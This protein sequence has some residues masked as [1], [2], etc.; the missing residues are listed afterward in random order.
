MHVAYFR[1]QNNPS[2]L[3]IA[4][5][6]T[7]LLKDYVGSSS[8]SFL[9]TGYTSL[10]NPNFISLH[11]D[12]QERIDQLSK[13]LQAQLSQPSLSTTID[14]LPAFQ[15]H[16]HIDN[17]HS[18]Q[19]K[20]HRHLKE[21]DHSNGDNI[22]RLS[23]SK[24]D[25]TV[26]C[27]ILDHEQEVKVVAIPHTTL[28]SSA[29]ALRILH[30]FEHVLR[31]VNNLTEQSGHL[32][33]K[34]DTASE[35]DINS[36]WKWNST[37]PTPESRTAL[38]VFAEHV[39]HRP[40]SLAV[41]AWDGDFT[42]AELDS[43]STEFSLRL[44]NEVSLGPGNIVPLC[45]EK[46]KWTPVA[47]LSVIKT[48]AAFTLIDENL[49]N[50]RLR[51]IAKLVKQ[52]TILALSSGSQKHRAQ[53]MASRVIIVDSNFLETTYPPSTKTRAQIHVTPDSLLYIVF[54]SGSTG[55]PKA[56]MLSHNNMC[57]FVTLSGALSDLTPRSRILALSSYAYDVSL[58]DAFISLLTGACLCI[59]SSWECKNNVDQ[60]VENYKVTRLMTTPSISKT[61]RPSDSPSLEVLVLCGEPCSED[62]LAR[63]RGSHT[64]I[65]NSY[66]PAE[67]TVET[68][69][70]YNV[71][72]SKKP[73]VIGKGLGACWIVDPVDHGR[74]AP[75]GGVGELVLEGPLV[76]LGYLHDGETTRKKFLDHA[77][78][79]ENG[80]PGL[81]NERKARLYRSGDLVRYT[82]DGDIEY[83][84]RGD[85]QVKIRGQ[86]VEL[87][88]VSAH[89]QEF[90]PP[91]IQWCPEV[92]KLESGAELLVVFLVVNTTDEPKDQ[93]S[94]RL[95]TLVDRVNTELQTRLP[96]S[97]VPSAYAEI[98]SV[99]LS[100]SGKVDHRRLK[101][102]G[103][104]LPTS[105]WIV[106][107]NKPVAEPSTN[108]SSYSPINDKK[109]S[110]ENGPV[111]GSTRGSREITIPQNG[112]G[113]NSQEQHNKLETL[114]RVWS[115][116]LHV[117]IKS[118]HDSDTFFSHGGESLTAIKFVSAASK[119][120]IQLDVATIF[121]YPQ[122]SALS[123]KAKWSYVSFLEPLVRFSLLNSKD[124][125]TEISSLYGI[126]IDDIEDA[127]PCT[128]LQE[129]LISA[130]SLNSTNYVGRGTFALPKDIDIE[131]FAQAWQRV[132]AVHSILRTRIVDTESNGL[133]QVV[134]RDG[135]VFGGIQTQPLASY[136]KEDSQNKL[137]LGT[138]L[139]RWG[140]VRH[141]GLSY[142]V[143]TM[144]HAIYDG[145]TLPR[146]GQE[147]FRA[148]NGVRIQPSVGFNIFV[149]HVMSISYK[150]AEEFWTRQL[151][152]PER[153]AAFP[154]LR[155][156][157]REPRADSVVS[158]S[159]HVPSNANQDTSI[160]SLLRAAWALLVSKL[161]GNDDVIFGATVS[162][163][164]VAIHGIEDL[165][166]P[167]ISTIPVRVRI[168]S[169]DSVSTF[170]RAVQNQA[171]EAMPFENLGLHNIRRFNAT[172]RD[173][174]KFQTLFIVDPPGE[175]SIDI[176]KSLSPSDQELKE[177]LEQLDDTLSA[178]LSNFNEYSLM[179]I[180]MQKNEQ[181]QIK[182]SYDSRILNHAD[183]NL[184]LDQFV[185]V[186]EQLG[187]SNNV[188]RSLRDLKLAGISDI[189]KIWQWNEYISPGVKESV[190]HIIGQTIS[191]HPEA[192]AIAA[193]DGSAS[194][195][196]LDK[197]SSNLCYSLQSKG[198]GR[199]SLVPICMEK[200]MWATVA[201]LAILKTG[202][203]F[204]AMDIISQPKKRL[205]IIVDQINATC[206]V[207]TSQTTDLARQLCEE[208][209]VCDHKSQYLTI[210]TNDTFK[211]D[212]QSQPSD[213]AFVVFTSGSTG[214]PKGIIITHENFST[215]IAHHAR[216]LKLTKDSRIFDFASYSFDI[217]VHNAL[218]ALSVGG[219]LCIPSE[220]DRK[221]DIEG[222]FK[223]LK[224]NWA[225]ITPSVARLIDPSAIPGLETLVLSGEAVSKDIVQTWGK[226]V[227][228][229][230]AYGPAECQICTVNGTIAG[231]DNAA[232]IGLGVACATWIV[233]LGTDNLTPIGAIGELVI[234][235][236]IVS[237][238]YLNDSNHSFI[239][240]PSWLTEGST[241]VPGRKGHLYRTG[242]LARYRPNGTIVYMGRASTQAKL[243]GQR[244]ELSEVEFYVKKADTSLK[245]VIADVVDVGGTNILTAFVVASNDG[246]VMSLEKD[247][248]LTVGP[249]PPPLGLNRAL[250]SDLPSYMI[251]G[252]FLQISH[253]PLSTTRKVDRNLLK[254]RASSISWEQIRELTRHEADAGET[255]LTPRQLDLA[256]IWSSVLKT[257]IAKITAHSDFFQLGGDS[258]S[259]MRLVKYSQ[260]MGLSFTVADVFRHSQLQELTSLVTE[261]VEKESIANI[262]QPFSLVSGK[263]VDSLVST[264]ATVCNV[265][266]DAIMD[267]YPCT[268]FQE[269][270]F[271]L[272]A[273]NSSAY[274]QHTLL[275]FGND[276]N[277]E[278][279]LGAWYAVIGATSILRTRLVQSEDAQL[280][281]VVVRQKDQLWNWYSSTEEYI[282]ETAKV[283][284]EL[285]NEL[286]R[287][288]VVRDNSTTP[289]SYI[290]IWTMHHAVYDAWTMDIILRQVSEYYQSQSLYTITPSY[291][292]FVDF[293]QRQEG[294]SAKWWRNYLSG[295]SN[296]SF[297]PKTPMSLVGNSV[298]SLTRKEFDLPRIIP[299][300]Y[301]PAVLLRAAWAIVMA[302]H[303]SSEAV[304]FG[305]TRLGRN[306]P[307]KDMEK[308]PGP[309]IASAPILLNVD[310]E[311]AI[312]SLLDTVRE[313]GIQM[314]EFEHLGLQNISRVSDD[315][316][317]ACNFQTLLVF[318]EAEDRVDGDSIFRVDDTI[319]DIRNFNNNHLLIY[320]SLTRTSLVTQAVF[321]EHAVSRGYVDLVL[322]QLHSTF[323]A[324]CDL[325]LHTLV[326]ELDVASEQDLTQIWEW[327]ATPAQTV[328]AFIHELIAQNA[329]KHP[330]KL[331]V[332]GHDGQMTYKELDQYSNNLAAQ[333]IARG[334][335]INTFVPLC[336]EKSF[337]VPAAI[338]KLIT[339]ALGAHLL[340]SSPSQV[341]LAQ[342]LG[343]NVLV[344]NENTYQ[345]DGALETHPIIEASPRDTDRLMYVCFTSGSTG[346]PKGVKVTHKNLA[347][348]AVAQTRELDFVCED[349]VYD[350]SS[351]AFDANIWHF[352]LGLV[353]GACVCIPSLEERT[354]NLAGSITA[355]KSTALFLTPSVARTI[356]PKD[357]PTVKRLYLGGEAVTPLDVSMWKDSL[358]L[359]GAYGPTETTPLCIFTR[360]FAPESA[361]N[362]GRGIGV[363]SWVV[364]PSNHDELVAIGAVGEMVNEGPLV[365]SGYH[366]LPKKTAQVFIE[367]PEFLQ[368]GFKRSRGR[369]GR[370]YKTGDL[371]RYCYDGTIQY[372]G[373]ADTQV[374]LR[375]QRV[376]FG[377]IEYHLKRA[378]P[379]VSTICD[380]VVHP[381]SG[382]P[383]LVA[384]CALSAADSLDK[385]S[386]RVYLSKRLPPYMVPEFFFRIE[387]IPRNKSGKVDRLNLREL[388][389][390]LLLAS[391]EQDNEG[392]VEYLHGP[393]T[394]NETILGALWATSLGQKDILLSPDTDFVDV[395]GDSIAA[396]KLS[397]L[398]R[399]QDI[400]LT[401]ADIIK[402]SKLSAMALSISSLQT[403]S[404]SPAPFSMINS[405]NREKI[406]AN[407]A[408]TCGVSVEDI[409]D[410]YPST[411]LQIELVAL[412]LKQ[413]QAYMKR[414]V[415]EVP[416]KVDVEKLV[417]AWEVVIKINA[418]LRTR[419]VE[420]ENIGLVQV[421]VKG[422]TWN[423][424]DSL[425]SYIDSSIASNRDLGSPLCQL[426]I[427]RDTDSSKIAWTIHHALYDEWSTLIID[428][429]LRRAY[430][431][432]T[433]QRPPSFNAVVAYIT[434]Q[435]RGKGQEFW[436]TRLSGCSSVN[437]YPQLPSAHYQV[438]PSQV[439]NCTIRPDSGSVRNLQA[440]VHAAW[441]LVVSK[442][443]GSNDVVFAATLAGR[444]IPVEG[445]EQV[446]GPTIT[447]VPIRIQLQNE[448]Q[449][450][451]ELLD[452]VEKD[453]ADMSPYQHMGIKNIEQ[454]NE[455]TRA[456]CKVQT[457]IV[458]TPS[459][460]SS[461][462]DANAI[463]TSTYDVESKEGGA[464][465]TFA[466]V[467]FVYPSKTHLDLQVVYDPAIFN[468][469]EIE[470]LTGRLESVI[471]SFNKNVL[472]SEID[473]LG[474]EDL[475]D[476]L[477]WNSNV[478]PSSSRLLHEVIL[479]SA[480]DNAKKL[481]IDAWDSK[482]SYSQLGKM[483]GALSM[484]LHNHGVG[485]GS[486][487]PILS[488]KSGY[489][490]VAALA[491]LKTGA[492]FL[493]LD[494]KQPL[495]RLV[496][497]IDQVKPKVILAA[498]SVR[499]LAT[500]L[501]GDIVLIE[502]CLEPISGKAEQFRHSD[503]ANIDDNACILFTSGT[504]GTPK[505]VMQTHRALSSAVQYQTAESGFTEKTR[506][507]EFA[508][509]SFDVSWNMIFKVLTVGGTLV[510][511]SE[512][513][514]HND[515]SGA[516]IRSAATLTELTASVARLLDPGQLPDLETLI[517]SGEP[518]DLREFEEW[519]P[520]A[521]VVVCY[522]PSECTSVATMN[523]GIGASSADAGIG[524]GAACVVWIVDPQNYRRLMPVGA[525]GEILIEGP[526]VGKG[527][528][529]NETL[530]SRSYLSLE[531]PKLQPASEKIQVI[532]PRKGFLS[533]DLARYDEDGNI[534][535][536]SRKDLQ[537]KLHGQRIELEEVQYHVS[538]LL[539][540]HVGPVVCCILGQSGSG[541]DQRL[542][543]FLV[544]D[545][546]DTKGIC[547]FLSP[548]QTTVNALEGLD[549]RIGAV[550]PKYMVPSVYYFITTLPR[551]HNGKI[552][553][554]RLMELADTAE[555]EHVYRGRTTRKTIR[556]NPS[557]PNEKA[558]Q[559]LWA[560]V[561]GTSAEHIGADDSF[562]DLNGDSISAM[563][564]VASARKLGFDLR[565]ADI[566]ATPKLSDLAVNFEKRDKK[567]TSGSFSMQPF[568]LLGGSPDIESI[569]SE[570]AVK[571]GI[572]AHE[573]IE[574][575][576]PCT[577]LQESMLAATIRY[578]GSFTSMR[579]YRV[580]NNVDESRLRAAWTRV[581]HVHRI[582]RT[583]LV[584]L[585]NYGVSQVIINEDSIAW[586]SYDSMHAF[587]QQADKIHMGPAT[588]LTRWAFIY[589][590]DKERYLV[591][592]IHHATYDGWTLQLIEDDVR[593]AYS[594]QRLDIDPVDIRPLVNYILTQRKEDS[595]AFWARQLAG[596]EDSVVFP[597]LPSHNYDPKPATYLEKTI[598][599]DVSATSG[600]TGL[601]GLLYGSWA[602]IVSHITGNQT[603]SL[604]TILTGRNAPIDGIDKVIGPAV[605]TVP[606]L[607]D[608]NMKLKVREFVAR[609]Q[610]MTACWI[611]HE[612]L[613]IQAIR[614]IDETCRAAC[615]FQ[616]V[617]VIQPP[618]RSQNVENGG[619]RDH[620]MEDVDETEV[621]GF[622]NQHS[623]LNQ[624]GLM[625]EVV[626]IDNTITVRA[627]FDSTL[628]SS[629]QVDRL[630]NLWEYMIQQISS[631]LQT[632]LLDTV[633]SLNYT[634]AQDLSDIWA[635][636]KNAPQ[637]IGP[638]R[639]VCQAIQS[640][641]HQQPDA[642][643]LDAWDGSMTYKRLDVLSSR[644]AHRLISSGVSRGH[645]VPLLFRKSLW[646]NV[647]M[648]AVLKAGGAFVPLDADHPEGHLRAIMQP[649]S[650]NIILCAAKTR[651]RAARLARNAIIVDTALDGSQDASKNI[652]QAPDIAP[653]TAHD[654]AY[655]VF[656]S[657]STGA[658][659]GVRISHENLAT[660]IH[661][662]AGAE[663]YQLNRHTRSLD[664]SSYSFDA[665]VCNFF[666]TVTQGGCL[667]VPSDETLK[668][669]IG[670]FINTSHV[671][672]AQLVPSVARTLDPEH[673]PNLKALVLTGE[674]LGKSDIEMW[675]HRVR[676]V[677]A[678]G[679]TE[680]TILCAIS[681]QISDHSQ[682]GS[683]GGGRGAN[684]W[685]TEIGNP[686][687]LATVGAVGEIL[688]EGP[689]VGAG[690]LGPY[691]YPLVENPS[692]LVSGRGNIP[693]RL[694]TLFR[695]G[696]Q[697]R[698]AEDGSIVFIGRI[699]SEIKLRGQRVDLAAIE[700]VVSS[701]IPRGLEFAAEIVQV[702][703]GATKGHERQM[704][705]VFVG[706]SVPLEGQEKTLDK[707]LQRLVPEL[708]SRLDA[709]LP[710]YL[711]P[712]AFVAFPEIPKTSSGK[713]DRRRLKELGTQIR[714]SQLTWIRGDIEKPIH[715]PPSSTI[716]SLL[717]TLWGE[718]LGIDSTT[719]SREDD[720]FQLGGDSLGVMRLTTKA[721]ERGLGLKTSDV[722]TSSKLALLA[723]RINQLDGTNVAYKPYSLARDIQD[724]RS[725]IQKHIAPVLK[726][727][728]SEVEDILPANGFQVDYMHSQEEPLGLQ[729]AYIDIG[730][731]T[732]WTKLIAACRTVVQTF[733]SLRARFV[734]HQGKYYQI[735]LR[736]APLA[737]E[738]VSTTEQI[739]TF[740]NRFCPADGHLAHVSDI[741]TKITLVHTGSDRR[742]V[743]LRLSHMQNDGWCT[744]RILQSLAAAFNDG[745]VDETP[746]WTSL[747]HYRD[748][749]AQ[750]SHL[751]WQRIL[752]KSSNLT[753]PLVY[754]P[755]GDQ[756][757][758]LRSYALPY[759][760]DAEDNRR[761]RPTVVVNVAWALVLQK[762]A[763]VQDAVFGN[764]TTGRNGSMPGLDSVVGPCVNML[765]FRLQLN[766][767]SPT[768]TRRQQILDL[769]EASAQQVDE[770][771][772]HEGLD[773]TDLVDKST[774]WSSGT[775]YTSAV[776]FRN[777][778]FEPELLL[779]NEKVVVT[780]Y[781]L[782]ARPHWTTV[783]VY[784][785]DSVLRLWLLA[786]PSEIGEDGADEILQMLSTYCEEIVKEL[787]S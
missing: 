618:R 39:A 152:D 679:P 427:I 238:G 348:A 520:R 544:N 195:S 167:T 16:L 712:E 28:S 785:E 758:T 241:S 710:V 655:A 625:M 678:Y 165:L 515:L 187:C 438:Q 629:T 253:I 261:V 488:P 602:A 383:M 371:V 374:K 494:S 144:H 96:P 571:C 527:Y 184:L 200:S 278:R 723:K 699:G 249:I 311:Q 146:L 284:M 693:G 708:K 9:A 408:A 757:R 670:S 266:R 439:F 271:A 749:S 489:V 396:M 573:K 716:E 650:A 440:K 14:E 475:E 285:G 412:T 298:N 669:D 270:V 295:A 49:P 702:N 314:Q 576:Y 472:V 658:A 273:S 350:F 675:A 725:F 773:W 10:D 8:V 114:K 234:E 603:V 245:E 437:V 93:I 212:A 428:E 315:A 142:L 556:R 397:N 107:Q 381:F 367:D 71:L 580:P 487:I 682:L 727:D 743:I 247:V 176:S 626:P 23:N 735:I 321:R 724:V 458:I 612:H 631:I 357:V 101:Q 19:T 399:K 434:S 360:L 180:I 210:G 673:L 540:G 132:T 88:E 566:F 737:V 56:I 20:S 526:I 2:K 239:R 633:A 68:V 599:A 168:D 553:R 302:R 223:R 171:L 549:E 454:I 705:V 538:K 567:W 542:A 120:G 322:N 143:L 37:V 155:N 63:W 647:A 108:G 468:R 572:D 698:Y 516:L 532:G 638:D 246:H 370:L 611:P 742:R 42:Y 275:R 387:D 98:D 709:Q 83:I 382:R 555:A 470:R 240:D 349:R 208:V 175:C 561:L 134:L 137:G 414:S 539:V 465:H 519:K 333:L 385:H 713:T 310:R 6:W 352:Y 685:L 501:A 402:H 787:R 584:D 734:N 425:Q 111:N 58:G 136:L 435:D 601:S 281:Q 181:L 770:R 486:V 26:K 365:T 207:T 634:S 619:K 457:L 517:L 115:D 305:E 609:I 248:T 388:G 177:T 256:Q 474:R 617:L 697:A 508:S 224:A 588:R 701:H 547:Q 100:L 506:A 140:I 656:T 782:V 147:V 661:Y 17:K 405:S 85:L 587:L 418:I 463:K 424:H 196:E 211:Q 296:A 745:I 170:V 610:D 102:L 44:A 368:R 738:E 721:H 149:K 518:V 51:Q 185:N 228:L 464:F 711:Q 279:V 668:G 741:F 456:A 646:A 106:W 640:I 696:D 753:S 550:L 469:R 700:Y 605:T 358:E 272:T 763:N 744:V 715:T 328:D 596:A 726:I 641:A 325:P 192:Q 589:G 535:F 70:N 48:G 429:Q 163:R 34:I 112:N 492:A 783:L 478:P 316:R 513:E 398:S 237:P 733:Q 400:G 288:G 21:T 419:F 657:G 645:F 448:N 290:L 301:S 269:A 570:V 201:M 104:S 534:H 563:K 718:V 779:G 92:V 403:S 613:G 169:N 300:G 386:T 393:L 148:Y 390:K 59:P 164:N 642:L 194:F 286:S 598:A 557:T 255:T 648:L 484:H 267:V 632:G 232:D 665:C 202:A 33:Y 334:V 431:E 533:G 608:V 226:K 766:T 528:Y 172:T 384:F 213:T 531:L 292:I 636:N 105:Q 505:G 89:L 523:P 218:M 182:A 307:V 574:D 586:D 652:D 514:R 554:K 178:A 119:V 568:Q 86:R 166:S 24:I 449:K 476:I 67:C 415:Y 7:V 141:L 480:I 162:G 595:K 747:L 221:N 64:R 762:L 337:L 303:T 82:D 252:L 123:I 230:N 651:D 639:F 591:W 575:V 462:E 61:L 45:F 623:V 250:K 541:E 739:T 91:S 681:S 422:H 577:P 280:F 560:A 259:A 378:L 717:A 416:A 688:I 159:V 80:L 614:S 265:S 503:I 585:H 124:G 707:S 77:P 379:H 579:L 680:C 751:Y 158:K 128:P 338:L 356:D 664:S 293:L 493:P 780:W 351:H 615:S 644:L 662:Q 139:C 297:F 407:T 151:A 466:L 666:Y 216:E 622:P 628:I 40:N 197:L 103:L 99:P 354:S 66:G 740:S 362:I 73:N 694:G 173:G 222:S 511:P 260:K 452:G 74:L 50:D 481:A 75:V 483:S 479:G 495:N 214:V 11:I 543:A 764:V 714:L 94:K 559:E 78:W 752:N 653:P 199:G 621:E 369:R 730:T 754:K 410:I 276:L 522:G 676:L 129:G 620:I 671:N 477:K 345:D 312:K 377:E 189:E 30:Q 81:A 756:V 12:E 203:G 41:N 87:G 771:T 174:S 193:W 760:H 36:V 746:D 287:F 3:E 131:R 130:E 231:V 446:V 569:R 776:H 667:C 76:G 359:W 703:L 332:V 499:E 445:V 283:P 233:D 630:I 578:P 215:T 536:V 25:L 126:E 736:D 426:A 154:P 497:V 160:P 62:A 684:L 355:F 524:K 145:W 327:N 659:K 624:Y 110:N 277:I 420:V 209:I 236:P 263:S 220:E 689:I 161:S 600:N 317:A 683:I 455:D 324:I 720:F 274:V 376:E 4:V 761:T 262:I 509:Y 512:E 57:T 401:I 755:G 704:L 113:V 43:L 436:K 53:L 565:V 411:P 592:T 691:Q 441:A 558:M 138:E 772:A 504:T 731:K 616:T 243:H 235:G 304:V 90:I 344:V 604:G 562:F 607:I 459:S 447:P 473:G 389:P 421:V 326:R 672:W 309:T 343:K 692:W 122:L 530:T 38:D 206:I 706:G 319:D 451:L 728:A 502:A 5:A 366:N 79:L 551:T 582:L 635:W 759:F 153:T 291:N 340:L 722:F 430:Q 339:E 774:T 204:V 186:A 150:Q 732:S 654:I 778:A 552:D 394:E 117:D 320:L 157:V 581:A 190:H 564:L 769:V 643:A 649:L 364:N 282:R 125:L 22:T 289:P 251:P 677:N 729:Y 308:I 391:T 342:R 372:L 341:V 335:G 467:L 306:V 29:Q 597:S 471:Y 118:I 329:Q 590:P 748:Q 392:G 433:I 674:A 109:L 406:L 768:T 786:N 54:T 127:Y 1:L 404:N 135:P 627:S 183:A 331:A 31:Q 318:L 156:G 490:P 375:G 84:G 264:A 767:D 775:R 268:A 32:V 121:G 336:F 191:L 205:K 460:K 72:M 453:T 686:N 687:K 52:E 521:R 548:K 546:R 35:W 179:I 750:A 198:I 313:D 254:E 461:S 55:V 299:P 242:D 413:P 395:G 784:P 373:R 485:R 13:S 380:V 229:I 765:P 594:G 361:S 347:S 491:V 97:M 294:T 450:T 442:I 95:R 593:K 545:K 417:Q 188:K 663:G 660:A 363:R 60:V 353:V 496:A 330:D 225:D 227:H 695:T 258:I 583:R 409:E 482:L 537:V 257:D 69:A 219:C 423:K 443:S 777:M 690:Y 529:G 444:N 323:S 606:I 65:I 637:P 116:I 133:L 217:A 498:G 27:T 500:S 525:V 244:I 510:V 346:V 781:E 432:R 18:E 46:S 507:F 47:M 15:T 719:I